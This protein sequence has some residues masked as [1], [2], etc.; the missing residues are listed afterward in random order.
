MRARERDEAGFFGEDLGL[1]LGL[2]RQQPRER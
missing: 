2:V 1:E